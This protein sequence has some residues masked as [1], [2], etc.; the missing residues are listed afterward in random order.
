MLLIIGAVIAAV[1]Q[2]SPLLSFQDVRDT[3]LMD[4]QHGV[5]GSG[6]PGYTFMA[7]S[8]SGAPTTWS[9][10]ARIEV[11]INPQGAPEGYA[12]MVASAV[13]R[14]SEASG[15][16]L[17]V[18]GETD[19]RDFQERGAG[20]VLLGWADEQ[21]LPALAGSTAGVG[22]A[23]YLRLGSGAGRSVGGMV[24]LDTD[25]FDR[26]LRAGYGEAIVMHELIH[27][28]GLGHTEDP[29]ELMAANHRGQ[30]E[31]G[32]GDLAGLQALREAACGR[33]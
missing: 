6:G 25:V 12:E 9:C 27:V 13:D 7:T 14:L 29:R 23:A 30:T 16:E 1:V 11:E 17:V 3:V 31:L 26:R 4:H 20:P 33:D 10:D 2:F 24:V 32:E 8:S 19:D 18:I 22:G 21:E 15:F 5:P 28:L